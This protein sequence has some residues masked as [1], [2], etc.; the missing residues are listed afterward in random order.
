MMNQGTTIY[1]EKI[2]HIIIYKL[3]LVRTYGCI[4][5]NLIRYTMGKEKAIGSKWLF[6]SIGHRRF[7]NFVKLYGICCFIH[8]LCVQY[9]P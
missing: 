5:M 8:Y 4:I 7:F 2:M 9:Y 3:F 1:V 6:K